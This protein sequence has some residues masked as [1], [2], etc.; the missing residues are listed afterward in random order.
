MNLYYMNN[1]LSV[2]EHK[3]PTSYDQTMDTIFNVTLSVT[4]YL[5]FAVYFCYSLPEKVESAWVAHYKNF[6][7]FKDFEYAF[8]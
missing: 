4:P 6:E 1:F 3:N 7:S 5:P 8:M 2:E